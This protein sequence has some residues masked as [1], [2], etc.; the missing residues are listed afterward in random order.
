L[1]LSNTLVITKM[2]SPVQR[3][4]S[5]CHQSLLTIRDNS[6]VYPWGIEDGIEVHSIPLRGPPNPQFGMEVPGSIDDPN[7]F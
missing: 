6:L 3:S 2:T 1:V 4:G 7:S 5:S